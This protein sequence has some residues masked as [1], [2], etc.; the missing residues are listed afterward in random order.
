[1]ADERGCTHIRT[2]EAGAEG[3]S[4]ARQ[5]IEAPKSSSSKVSDGE[6][7]WR[8]LAQID[9]VSHTEGMVAGVGFETYDLQVMS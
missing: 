6:G 4:E 7:F 1:M 8:E 2:H 9:A 3:Q 5:D